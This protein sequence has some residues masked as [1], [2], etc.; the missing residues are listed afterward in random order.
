MITL[1]ALRNL[2]VGLASINLFVGPALGTELALDLADEPKNQALLL[3]AGMLARRTFQTAFR[4]LAV[5]IRYQRFHTASAYRIRFASRMISS[6]GNPFG[7]RF[8]QI[9]H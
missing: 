2:L 5:P 9:P 1:V 8:S 6:T 3:I 7:Q 4:Q